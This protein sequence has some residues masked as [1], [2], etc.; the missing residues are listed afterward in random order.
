MLGLGDV[1]ETDDGEI[2]T[3]LKP[4][5][6]QSQHGAEGDGVVEAEGSGR[7]FSHRQGRF[8]ASDT[9]SAAGLPLDDKRVARGDALR[10][11]GFA[12]SAR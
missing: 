4:T 9:A 8:E 2:R 5:L 7:R 12:K 3:G 1:V 10:L 6:A 11:T